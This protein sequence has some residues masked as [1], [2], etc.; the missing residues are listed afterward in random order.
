[1]G[2]LRNFTTTLL[3]ITHGRTTAFFIAFFIAG[4]AMALAGKLTTIYVAYLATLGGLV[5]GHS[6][7]EDILTAR[8]GSPG[9]PPKNADPKG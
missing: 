1:M 2:R 5:L 3:E 8:F 4:H 7:K 6:V 9:G